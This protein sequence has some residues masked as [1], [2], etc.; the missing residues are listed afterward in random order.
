MPARPGGISASGVQEHASAA[1]LHH[2]AGGSNRRDPHAVGSEI[3]LA[4]ARAIEQHVATRRRRHRRHASSAAVPAAR[5]RRRSCPP[6]WAASTRR[7]SAWQTL[8][9]GRCS[10]HRLLCR[11][12]RRGWRDRRR[13]NRG[14][15][16]RICC[17]GRGGRRECRAGR[18][19]SRCRGGRGS[20]EPPQA[21][22]VSAR[23]AGDSHR[24]HASTGKVHQQHRGDHPGPGWNASARRR[25][26][27][28]HQH[29]PTLP[30]TLGF[31]FLQ[32]VE[33][34]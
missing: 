33:D 6:P 25:D 21:E 18:N 4:Q 15:G 10:L 34:E 1:P 14:H 30:V 27:H 11:H 5:R 16:S 8:A 23:G 3:P 32:R 9:S 24:I 7:C 17:D 19:G 20:R 12:L 31:G 22:A 29:R 26:A 13:N 28:V 2:H